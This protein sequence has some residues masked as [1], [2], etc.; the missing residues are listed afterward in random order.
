MI[1]DLLREV[2]RRIPY[3]FGATIMNVAMH[4]TGKTGREGWEVVPGPRGLPKMVLDPSLPFQ[5]RMYF[6]TRAYWDRLLG[7]PFGRFAQKELRA[8]DTFVDIGAN[9]GFYSLFAAQRVGRTG[10]VIAFEPEPRTFESLERSIQENGFAWATPH[11]MALSDREGTLPFH[12]VTDGSAHSL[13]SETPER[14]KR[15]AGQVDVRVAT[16]DGLALDLSRIDLV[17]IDVEGEE[18]RTVR[19]ML[20]TLKKADFPL[21]WAEVRGPKGSTRA[22]DTYP[23]VASALRTLDYEPYFWMRDH[24]LEPVRT[25]TKRE[26]VLFVHPR[27]RPR[28]VS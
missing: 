25:V 6:F 5:R 4:A 26:D 23:A 19:G 9:I 2:T 13:V 1:A 28:C 18:P 22:P 12:F 20:E 7:L 15:Y 11:N 21:V 14:S 8:G 24:R 17:K 3:R 27:R 16:L 10:R